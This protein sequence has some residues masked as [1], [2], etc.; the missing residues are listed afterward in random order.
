MKDETKHRDLSKTLDVMPLMGMR[1]L[2]CGKGGSGKSSISTLLAYEL[3]N[4]KY[5]I[6]LLD[7]D[8]SNPGGLSRM[9]FGLKHGPKPLFDFF[10]GREFV[11][12]PIDNP[13]PLTRKNDKIAVTEKNIDLSEIP[14]EY[15]VERNGI[16]LMQVGKINNAFEGCDGPMSKIS[17]DFIVMGDQ[18]TLIDVEAGIEHFGRGIEQ[19]IDIILIIVDPTYE[20]FF[21]AQKV[22]LLSQQMGVNYTWAILNKARSRETEQTIENE[23]KNR[24]VKILGSINYDPEIELAGLLGTRLE[25]SEAI[26]DIK[27]IV[28]ML[29]EQIKSNSIF[30]NKT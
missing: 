26:K 29:E 23:L 27:E 12:C 11:E 16:K 6:L 5:S 13:D 18:V 2:I 7:G 10:G 1:I 24:D 4:K 19:N 21:V 17:R 9:L 15:I 25:K 8:A 30:N 20:S 3:Q 14:H 22:S 28:E